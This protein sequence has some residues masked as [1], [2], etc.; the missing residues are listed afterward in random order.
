MNASITPRNQKKPKLLSIIVPAYN[1]NEVI[2]EFYDRL[3]SVLN[4]IQQNYEVV[5]INDGSHDDTLSI[6]KRL[7]DKHEII[8]IVDLSRNFGK[9]IATTAGIDCAKG[10]ATIIIDAD[11]AHRLQ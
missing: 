5:F 1:E 2:E 7:R 6:M 4:A 8:T 3:S 10:D 9:E 11:G